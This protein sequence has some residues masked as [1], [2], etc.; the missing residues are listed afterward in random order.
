MTLGE[1]LKFGTAL[2]MPSNLTMKSTRSSGTKR[3]AHGG[4]KP[5]AN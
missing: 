1:S 5:E 3:V 4:K 2:T